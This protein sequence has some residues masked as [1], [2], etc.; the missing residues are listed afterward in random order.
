MA[1]YFKCPLPAG[2]VSKWLGDFKGTSEELAE[3]LSVIKGCK[4]DRESDASLKSVVE[5]M[6]LRSSLNACL[7]IGSLAILPLVA[8]QFVPLLSAE[9]DNVRLA[10]LATLKMNSVDEA[11]QKK[12]ITAFNGN[13][14]NCSYFAD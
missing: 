13:S 5:R 4:F 1:S 2:F 3:A 8:D 12:L 9:T 14:L 11:I 7:V 10:A 6:L